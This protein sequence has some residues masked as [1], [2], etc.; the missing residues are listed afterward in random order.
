M[1]ARFDL[2]RRFELS[3]QVN[4]AFAAQNRVGIA[5]AESLISAIP[6]VRKVVGPAGLLAL[7]VDAAGRASSGP[8]LAG[9]PGDD[10]SE[11]V[12]QRLVRRSDAV[13]WFISRDGTEIRLLV[14]TDDLSVGA[15]RD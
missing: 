11:A 10:A 6:G 2:G 9:G 1:A 8:L 4:N 5:R 7:S 13:G 12:R 14:D 3:L 15:E